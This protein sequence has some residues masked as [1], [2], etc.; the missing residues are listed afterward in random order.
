[1]MFRWEGRWN[2]RSSFLELIM[3]RDDQE[4]LDKQLSRVETAPPS[5]VLMLAV[6]TVFFAGMAIGG[7]LFAYTGQPPLRLASNDIPGV[8]QSSP[9]LP[10]P[11]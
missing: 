4:L 1:M 2:R 5:G 8:A 11:R 7:F 9:P 6:A 3:N 10:T